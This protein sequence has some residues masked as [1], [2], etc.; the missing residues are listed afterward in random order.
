VAP[1]SI[2]FTLE[3]ASGATV[4]ATLGYDELTRTATLGSAS[5]LVAATTYTATVSSATDLAGNR[6]A[7][8][9]SWPFTV[10]AANCPGSISEPDAIPGTA[11]SMDTSPIELGVKF[12]VDVDGQI[13]GVRF[14]KGAGN[15]GTHVGSI[16]TAV[17]SRLAVATFTGESAS[18][19]Q[20]VSFDQPVRVTAGTTY[21]ASYHA[22]NGGYA[23]DAGAFAN[24]GAGPGPVRA[25][26]SD[27]ASGNGVYAYGSG[28]FPTGSFRASNY[29]VDVVFIPD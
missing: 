19:W 7:A 29:W 15:T 5:T 13:T 11:S 1:S 14:Y 27:E 12:R 26:A 21:V 22:P 16:W 17:G 10:A 6:M 24:K 8:A 9:V 25:L 2:G 4:P 20:Q 23:V 28:D 18:G 3:T